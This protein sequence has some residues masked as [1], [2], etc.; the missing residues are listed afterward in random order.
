M[1]F[2]AKLE[3][4]SE[5]RIRKMIEASTPAS[6]ER[7]LATE[8]RCAVDLAALLC[9]HAERYLE[10]LA[11]EGQRLTRWHFGRTIGLYA[12]VY[13]SN[14]CGADCLYCGFATQSGYDQKRLTLDLE[15][16]RAE[17]AALAD[18]GFKSV[19]FVTGDAP[20]AVDIEYLVRA[21]TIGR[22]Y[23][24][25]VCV[26]V[27]AMD[28]PDYERLCQAGLEGVTLYMETF[29]RDRYA[30]VHQKGRKRDFVYRLDALERAGNAG[31]RRLSM[32]VLLGLSDWRVDVF[33]LALHARH[34]QRE[35]WQSAISISFPRLRH[36]P[37]RFRV[38]NPVSDL[39]LVQLM[40]ALRLFLPEA[41]F[42]LST[43]ESAHLRDHLI[44][45]G[46]TSMSAGSSTRPGG[47]A[48]FGKETLEQFAIDDERSPEEVAEAIR[49]V[50]YDPVWKDFD[51]A[52]DDPSAQSNYRME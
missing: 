27:Y 51:L 44:P 42:N 48:T 23:F 35:C 5:D 49:R 3:Q 40:L 9:P 18:R 29:D 31:A 7:A 39:E 4:W 8:E 26:E 2:E 38:P 12:P 52:F 11:Q 37:D 17:C 6:V 43:R 25:S 33:R 36:V 13:L 20:A 16:V 46:I 41:G 24:P 34:L 15:S 30:E 14:V 28:S 50:G 1:S 32:G 47:Y 45:L 19:L 22:E 10:S 21:V